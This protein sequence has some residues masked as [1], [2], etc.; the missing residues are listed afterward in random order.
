MDHR[1][2]FS[3]YNILLYLGSSAPG[4]SYIHLES[5]AFLPQLLLSAVLVP[6][7][8]AKKDLPSTMLAQTFAFVTFNKVCTSQVRN[9]STDASCYLLTGNA[10]LSLVHCFPSLLSSFFVV[11]EV[12]ATRR[13]RRAH[14]GPI[15]SS[16]AAASFPVGIPRPKHIYSRFVDGKPV[17]LHG[18]CL[19]SRNHSV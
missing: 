18:E 5:A 12:P 8:L 11:P 13:G 15:T 4:S 16:M 14:L 17:F 19:D 1:H 7:L 10:V 9:I 6:L 3:P 2:N